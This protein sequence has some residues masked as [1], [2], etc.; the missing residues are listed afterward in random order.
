MYL[1]M[2]L[3]LLSIKKLRMQS[4]DLAP[5]LEEFGLSEYEARAYLVLLSKGPLSASELAYYANL[6]RTKVYA[7]LTK[8]AKKGL[9]VITQDK[10]VVCNA[11]SPEDAFSE[12]VATQEKRVKG[13]KN[14]IEN[15]QK[16]NYE[17]KPHGAE[18]R[19][20]LVLDPDSVLRMLEELVSTAKST[21]AAT[22]DSWGIRLISQ[23]KEA[24]M[25]VVAANVGVKILVSKECT[26]NDLLS[27]LPNGVS[28]K[29]GEAN[30]GMF[31]FDKFTVILVDSSN[32]KG[33]L[34]RSTDVVGNICNRIF[35]NAW[36]NGKDL[37]RVRY[38]KRTMT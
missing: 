16:I 24:L 4:N 27:L 14:L 3:T 31:I 1:A 36:N 22:L 17:G 29:I 5:N 35:D 9:A 38:A 34:F 33:V 6:P 2:I 7:T 12:L 26:S 11:I 19:R 21:V 13:M 18:E 10:P 37:V 8:L 23:C 25:K 32:G 15:L 28:V 20:Y 30:A